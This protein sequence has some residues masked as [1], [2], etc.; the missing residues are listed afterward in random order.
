M[1]EERTSRGG[2]VRRLGTT[3]ALG[4]GVGL[5]GAKS[6][7]GIN[8]I[9]CPNSSCNAPCQQL[10]GNQY[11][12][13]YLCGNPCGGCCTCEATNTGCKTYPHACPC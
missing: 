1:E 11:P 12:V 7:L 4:L 5:F 13:G 9:C 8:V 3:L 10:F 2:F 6:A